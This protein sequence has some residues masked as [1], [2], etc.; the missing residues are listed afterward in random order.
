[1]FVHRVHTEIVHL[2]PALGCYGKCLPCCP[3]NCCCCLMGRSSCGGC[4]ITLPTTGVASCWSWPPPVVQLV[5]K[6]CWCLV[7]DICWSGCGGHPIPSL[8]LGWTSEGGWPTPSVQC[9]CPV[10]SGCSWLGTVWRLLN[11]WARV[12]PM[13][14]C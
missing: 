5:W 4:P 2:G 11:S 9:V 14:P 7:P 3:K 10:C 1:M 8:P 13:S 12:I 6:C